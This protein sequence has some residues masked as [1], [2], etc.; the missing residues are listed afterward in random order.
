[1]KIDK[2]LKQMILDF[3][4]DSKA[5]NLRIGELIKMLNLSERTIQKWKKKKDLT[6]KRKGSEKTVHNKLSESEREKVV[7]YCCSHE[8]ADLTAYVIYHSL[9]DRGIY[10]C[11]PRTIYRILQEEGL[12]KQRGKII[13]KHSE[14]IELKATGIN[15][16]YSWDISYIKTNVKGIYYYLYMFIDIWS[17]TIIGWDVYDCE[18][19]DNARKLFKEIA[20]EHNVKNAILHSDNGSPMKSF[21]FRATLEKLGVK[22]SFSRPSVSNDNAYSESLFKT[23]KYDISYPKDFRN[24]DEAKKWIGDFVEWYNYKHMH[25]KIGYVTP[26]ERHTG[27]DKEIFKKRNEVITKAKYKNPKRWSNN[28]KQYNHCNVVFLKKGNYKKSS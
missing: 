15:Q 21:T 5:E 8:Y 23:L 2:D 7:E 25:S 24:I 16:I 22:E 12:N 18:S 10:I 17:R 14:S 13:K 20:E 6:D 9:L 26:M 28:V 4:K 3:L 11:S 27:K 1:M 19:G